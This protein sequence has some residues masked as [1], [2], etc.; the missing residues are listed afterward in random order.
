MGR[1]Q[2]GGGGGGAGGGE[3]GGVVR[4]P[5]TFVSSDTSTHRKRYVQY[6]ASKNLRFNNPLIYTLP[7]TVL[8]QKTGKWYFVYKFLV[9]SRP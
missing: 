4:D 9:C 8:H 2:L 7:K 3:G 6:F 1:G 5:L